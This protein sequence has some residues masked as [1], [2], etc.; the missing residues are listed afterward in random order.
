[1]ADTRVLKT[2]FGPLDFSQNKTHIVDYLAYTRQQLAVIRD[3]R[4]FKQLNYP[5]WWTVGRN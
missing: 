4:L 5:A 1:M 2:R 3:T